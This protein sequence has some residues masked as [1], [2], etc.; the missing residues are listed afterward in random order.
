MLECSNDL[1]KYLTELSFLKKTILCSWFFIGLISTGYLYLFI[2]TPGKQSQIQYWPQK[3]KIAVSQDK[4]T[5]VIFFHPKCVCS[6]AS[7]DELSLLLK[8][9]HAPLS[10]KLV[11]IRYHN[12]TED[13]HKTDLYQRASAVKGSEVL[14]DMD[15]LSAKLLGASTSGI[16]FLINHER[17]I[18]FQ[19]GLTPA[20]GNMGR[21]PASAFIINWVN[22][23]AKTVTPF[24]SKVFGCEL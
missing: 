8:E 22:T 18:V 19:G 24:L 13:W 5:L 16:A 6:K 21:T 3:S 12:K 23:K 15:G 9:V 10:V 2:T 14:N 1:M 4:P 17:K 11:F 7:F 20:R